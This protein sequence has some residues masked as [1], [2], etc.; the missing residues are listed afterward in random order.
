MRERGMPI[1][2]A[3]RPSSF[4]PHHSHHN[5]TSHNNFQTFKSLHSIRLSD[6]QFFTMSAISINTD[7][8]E[9]HVA[10]T[11]Y[12]PRGHN[13]TDS[14]ELTWL[15][16]L[17]NINKAPLVDGIVFHCFERQSEA[18]T[19]FGR[20]FEINCDATL[21][22]AIAPPANIRNLDKIAPEHADFVRDAT[23]VGAT[24][25]KWILDNG[26]YQ[27]HYNDLLKM[28]P[29]AAGLFKGCFKDNGEL[30]IT[31]AFTARKYLGL[32]SFAAS[33]RKHESHESRTPLVKI[34]VYFDHDVEKVDLVSDPLH[35]ALTIRH[36]GVSVVKRFDFVP[37]TIGTATRPAV[38]GAVYDR[39][40][41]GVPSRD[42]LLAQ[43]GQLGLLYGDQPK[44]NVVHLITGFGLS[45]IDRGTILG[46]IMNLTKPKSLDVFAPNKGLPFVANHEA[47]EQYKGRIKYMSRSAGVVPFPRILHDEEVRFN[48]WYG[49]T[50]ALSS[51]E[52]QAL[53]MCKRGD[54][55]QLAENAIFA[56][57]A[58]TLGI[59]PSEVHPDMST[60]E[61]LESYI[62]QALLS[63]DAKTIEERAMQ[64]IALLR[65]AY[66]CLANGRGLHRD[67]KAVG[68]KL[69]EKFPITRNQREGWRMQ[70]AWLGLT[71]HP[72]VAH[73]GSNAN[74]MAVWKRLQHALTASP[75]P[76]LAQIHA[77]FKHGVAEH[78]IGDFRPLDQSG[79]TN[80]VTLDD[81]TT[82]ADVVHQSN[83]ISRAAEPL[84]KQMSGQVMEVAPT[85][86]KYAK[87]RFLMTKTGDLIHAVDLGIGGE[88]VSVLDAQGN[89]ST[90]GTRWDDSNSWWSAQ[91][92]TS[93]NAKL[94]I[95]FAI[96]K[97]Q[98]VTQ[99]ARLLS[100][101]R[102]ELAPPEVE[103]DEEVACLPEIGM[104]FVERNQFLRLAA[105]VSGTDGK[106]Y[107]KL[108][109]QAFTISGRN[110]AVSDMMRALNNEPNEALQQALDE[111]HEDDLGA[112]PIAS[113]AEFKDVCVD[114]TP[115]EMDRVFDEVCR[116]AEAGTLQDPPARA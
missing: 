18:N 49:H 111:Y 79:E 37:F 52:V 116:R 3:P 71:T 5:H 17:A 110:K 33:Q 97:S 14:V 25:N 47:M 20:T 86:P 12:G 67:A 24:I 50:Q 115:E 28:N 44:H 51:V 56:A 26:G 91:N 89:S 93:V 80:M 23:D 22:G 40:I 59:V 60:F 96:M 34:M 74:E 72:S 107:A 77:Q 21:N 39:A 27:K 38:S 105:K 95:M 1:K 75:V 69:D 82:F 42:G 99:F 15:A 58:R 108:Y 113:Y 94:Y 84:Y 109:D 16:E 62:Q 57:I 81:D 100:Q 104:D 68:R 8:K 66:Q 48:N 36:N 4:I 63:L 54:R 114:E 61:R 102:S 19:R 30:D 55:L 10:I 32:A 78:V 9:L 83:F 85:Q 46:G 106:R 88:G 92:L 11:G 31:R 43:L 7:T 112:F 41:K 35:P 53:F 13:T 70:R 64:P 29:A 2:T 65:Q 6:N 98:G 76:V 45:A 103:F 73:L 87:N 90:V 101:I